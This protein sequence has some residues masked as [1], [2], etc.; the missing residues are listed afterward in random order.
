VPRRARTTTIPLA[1]FRHL[2]ASVTEEMGEALRQSA[3]SPNVKERRDYSCA[4]LDPRGRL[5]SHAAHIPVHLGSAHLTVPAVLA[6]VTIGRGDV[7]VVNDPHRGGTHLNDVTVVAPLDHGGRRLGYLLDRAHHADVGGAEPGSLAGASDVFGE[8]LILPPVHLIRAGRRVEEVWR[9]FGANT[10][11]PAARRADLEAQC[12]ALHRGQQRFAELRARFGAPALARAMDGLHAHARAQAAA[13]LRSWPDGDAAASDALDGP[14][15]PVIAC[16]VR[17]RGARLRL[18]FTG[19]SPQVPGSW[20]TH[21]AVAASA[22][23]YVLRT[24]AGEDLPESSGAL[25]AVELRLPHASVLASEAPAGVAAGNTET[26][27][28][29]VDVLYAALAGLLGARIP[30]A[31]QGSMNNV[32]FGGRRAG[33]GEY[34][35]YETIAGGAGAGPHGP[36]ASGVQVHMTNTRNTP[37]EVFE[38]DAPIRVTRL[39][40]RRGAGGAGRHRG[41][42]GV[43]KEWE[44]LAPTRVSLMTTRRASRPP[45]AHGGGPGQSG[46]DWLIRDGRRRRLPASGSFTAQAGDRLRIETPGG[47]GWGA[48]AAPRPA[49]ARATTPRRRR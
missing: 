4:L 3:V 35:H 20:N 15:T 41:G 44:F 34:V 45:G 9:I 38:A 30:A 46:A 37:V 13:L 19:S 17:K 2:Y 43:V 47:G 39:A 24:L 11:D 1:A 40:L 49:T 12:A 42:D 5:V 23:F 26:S 33:G 31:S 8:G 14:G 29:I 28:R 21:R 48:A 25:E 10:R 6:E 27:Q 22:A 7:I 16:A 36:G 32:C 18:D